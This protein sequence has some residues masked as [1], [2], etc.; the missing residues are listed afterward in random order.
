MSVKYQGSVGII[1]KC[2]TNLHTGE[3]TVTPDQRKRVAKVA[4]ATMHLNRIEK[5]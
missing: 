5:V 2:H 3:D 4:A 1:H